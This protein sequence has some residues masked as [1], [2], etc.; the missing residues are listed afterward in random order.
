MVSSQ[1]TRQ[2]Q[3]MKL[4]VKKQTTT[5]V[6]ILSTCHSLNPV[7]ARHEA[8]YLLMMKGIQ[9]PLSSIQRIGLSKLRFVPRNDS[10]LRFYSLYVSFSKLCHCEARSNPFANGKSIQ[11]LFHQSKRL[12]RAS[13]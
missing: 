7:I 5:G 1:T 2:I 13:Q 4:S 3:L 12:L 9:T 8:I 10:F 11:I 6:F